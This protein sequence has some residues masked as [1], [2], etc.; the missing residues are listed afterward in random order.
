MH[1]ILAELEWRG[2]Y[3]D[4]TDR[5]A[6]AQRLAT[7]PLALYCGFDPTADSLHVGNLVPLFALRRFQLAGH[8]PI[9]LAGG[10][11]GMVGDPSGKSDERNLQTPE[12]VAHNIAAVKAQLQK[13]L[14]F[15]A[16][17]TPANNPARLVNNADWTAPMTFLEFLRDVGKFITVNSMIAKDSVRSRMDERASG[18]SF[19]EFSYMLLQGY[20]F[21]H[22]RQALN[23]ELQVGAT[24]QWGNIT[25]GTEL[26]RKKLCA[27]VWGLVFPLLTKSDGS[28]YGKTAT[29]T[30]WL[31]PKKTSP[32]RFYQ[33]FVNAD[34]ADVIKLLK[35]LTFLSREEI[36]ALETELAANPGAR[37]AQKALARE[38]TTL[39]H[40]ADALAAALK[41]SDIL[42][43]GSLDGVTEEIFH[44]VVGEVPTKDLERA[45][46][47][48]AGSAIADLIVHAGL[49][50][51]KGAARK[52]LEAGGVYLNNVR[53]DHT[54]VVTADDLLFGKYLLL[55]KGKRTYAVL[56]AR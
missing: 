9:A 7:G 36:T 50:P 55:R 1:D 46:L 39:V 12:Q 29:G 51:S 41:A 52:S 17:R 6:L 5:D 25:V 16:A 24:D 3:A 8:H 42:F 14:E 43:G 32:Y 4:C 23:C 48:G 10:A 44:D 27:T 47:E 38:M 35:T 49:E 18:I 15:D 28:K 20:D 54:R 31:D 2:L 13:F 26:T 45:K 11:T 40:G 33:F 22:L 19:T 53:V 21:F 30:V 37:A 56:I 34:D